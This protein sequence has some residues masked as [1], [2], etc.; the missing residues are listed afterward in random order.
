M[1]PA[2]RTVR[3]A[4]FAP[5]WILIIAC[6]GGGDDGGIAPPTIASVAITAPATAPTFQTLTR[7]A[8][9][10]AVAR[11]AAAATVSTTITWNSSNGSVASVSALGLVT[12]TG[13][14]TTQITASAGGVTSPAVTVTVAQVA[15]NVAV[16]PG[17]VA[18]GA[19]GASRQLTASVVDSSGAAVAGATA[20]TWTRAGTGATASVSAGGL[21]TA[22]AVGASDTAV[23]SG[24]GFT[25]RIPIAVSQ[26]VAQVVVSSTGTDTLRTTGRTKQYTAVARDSQANI[27]AG[28]GIA[29]SSS[30]GGVASVGA[31]T[32]IATA[33]GDGTTNIIATSG[34]VAGQR[35]L[36][37]RRYAETFSHTPPTATI[38]TALGTQ[39]FLGTAE[40]SV[41]TPLPISWLSRTTSVLTV[42]P[43]SGAQTT[44]TA[45][46]NGTSY[47]V[48]QAGTRSDSS[49]VT[50]SGQV[51]FPMTATVLV[52]SNF[53]RSQRNNTQNAAV[54]TIGVGGNVTWQWQDGTHNV[55]P[56]GSPT[57]TGSGDRSN[58]SYVFAFGAVGTYQYQCTIHPVMTGRVVVR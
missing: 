47:V 20:P 18:F 2:W 1:S 8:Q 43:A 51:T 35:A 22:L 40:D 25:G 4:H 57:F 48:M 16:T 31:A 11:D 41:A 44:A 9:F 23:A 7:T 37:V 39:L 55:T 6:S 17:T 14:G 15:A 32:G 27:I 42:S 50:V 10:T 12:A 56:S 33:V 45:A 28:A 21:A 58:G 26:V 54:D 30:A 38:T 13:N 53:F 19:I 52:G 5:A 46:G 49:L 29:W 36:T 24:G 3:L 34:G